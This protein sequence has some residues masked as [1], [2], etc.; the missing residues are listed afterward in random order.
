MTEQEKHHLIA[1]I[2]RQKKLI[3][4][5]AEIIGELTA[6]ANGMKKAIENLTS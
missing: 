6:I 1:L 2:D 5:Q 4:R 3:L